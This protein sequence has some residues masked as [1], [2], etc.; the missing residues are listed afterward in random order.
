MEPITV[1]L[2]VFVVVVVLNVVGLLV[3]F[4]LILLGMTTITEVVC[5]RA[6]WL[7]AVIIA[8]QVVGVVGLAYHFHLGSKD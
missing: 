7:G 1:G 6:W 3:D 4:I 8:V 5:C 2:V